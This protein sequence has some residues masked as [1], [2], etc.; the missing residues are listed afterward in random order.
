MLNAFFLRPFWDGGPCVYVCVLALEFSMVVPNLPDSCSSFFPYHDFSA[1]ITL[2]GRPVYPQRRGIDACSDSPADRAF[3]FCPAPL[4]WSRLFSP[5][6]SGGSHQSHFPTDPPV[7]GLA[8]S[9]APVSRFFFTRC[10]LPDSQKNFTF[11]HSPR[12]A[13]PLPLCLFL[14]SRGSLGGL[15]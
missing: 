7:A 12:P 5:L 11:L 15:F 1:Q 4:V 10:F 13:P 6:Y 2:K 3:P 9:P 8:V 14:N